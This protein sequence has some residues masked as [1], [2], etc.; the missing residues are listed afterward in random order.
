MPYFI[1]LQ[2]L[3]V[4][5]GEEEVL[6]AGLSLSLS[7][8]L[9]RSLSVC[10]SVC[11]SLSYVSLSRPPSVCLSI[12]P[13]RGALPVVGGEEKVLDARALRRKHLCDGRGDQS[14]PSSS[15]LSL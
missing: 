11:L 10:L 2:G 14:Q 15:S 13:Q 5:G 12:F 9:S 1:P 6:D 8:F 3:P 7:L 4:V